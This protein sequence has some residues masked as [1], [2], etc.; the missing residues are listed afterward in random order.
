MNPKDFFWGVSLRILKRWS[1]AG[2][3]ESVQIN[4]LKYER[5]TVVSV[6]GFGPVDK[7]FKNYVENLGGTYITFDIDAEHKP[8]I[9]GDVTEISSYLQHRKVKPDVILALE[10]LEHVHKFSHAIEDCRNALEI[11]GMLIFS[12]PWII[13]IHDRPHDYFRFTPEVLAAHLREF[14]KFEIRARGDYKDSVVM[15]LLRGLFSGGL[16]G[17]FLMIIGA[18]VSYLLPLPKVYTDLSKIDSCIGYLSIGH[19]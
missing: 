19:K 13:P 15:L 6:G 1:R 2:L 18:L 16:A 3:I 12:T 5:P 9:V 14:K 11:N 17:K 7:Y 10:V 8:D 4:L